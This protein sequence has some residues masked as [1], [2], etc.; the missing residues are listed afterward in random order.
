M[1]EICYAAGLNTNI[2]IFNIC[3]FNPDKEELQTG[4]FDIICIYK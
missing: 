3:D 1:L 2:V 4:R